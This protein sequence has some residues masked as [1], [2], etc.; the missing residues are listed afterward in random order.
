VQCRSTDFSGPGPFGATVADTYVLDA[1]IVG[2]QVHVYQVINDPIKGTILEHEI[3][4]AN[5]DIHGQYRI[6]VVPTAT[7]DIQYR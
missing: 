7:T 6:A 2:R 3:G 5:T 4:N 1:P